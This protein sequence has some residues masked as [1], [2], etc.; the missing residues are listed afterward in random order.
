MHV[1][2]TYPLYNKMLNSIVQ[3]FLSFFIK[4]KTSRC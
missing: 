2:Y 4:L 1:A 3:T